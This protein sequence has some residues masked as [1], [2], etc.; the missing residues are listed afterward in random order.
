M[1]LRFVVGTDAEN[2]FWL[3]GVITIAEKLR[4]GGELFRYESVLLE[5]SFDWLNEYLPC[6]P[7]GA[8]IRSGEWTRN[9]VSW[10]R[11]DADEAIQRI[12][13]IVAVL[14]EHGV[15]V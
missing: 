6:P 9:A 2:A 4:K 15:F 11:D 7:F 8:K 3:T 1:F 13:D 12:W 14:K 10:F 5:A